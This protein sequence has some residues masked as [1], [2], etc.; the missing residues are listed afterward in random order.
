MNDNYGVHLNSSRGFPSYY[1]NFEL[2]IEKETETED[3][4]SDNVFPVIADKD[5][6]RNQF[7]NRLRLR[8]APDFPSC[9]NNA[10]VIET[11]AY[12]SRDK[13]NEHN[14]RDS[15]SNGSEDENNDGNE[16]LNSDVEGD[17]VA[18]E[19][20]LK[21]DDSL[22]NELQRLEER[23]ELDFKLLQKKEAS[24]KKKLEIKATHLNNQIL[25]WNFF[26]GIRV[27]LDQVLS[28][29]N[30]MPWPLSYSLYFSDCESSESNKKNL[31]KCNK[32]VI[33]FLILLFKLQ[34]CLI[35][36]NNQSLNLVGAEIPL[37][38][39]N[40][41]ETSSSLFQSRKRK[42]AEYESMPHGWIQSEAL[43]WQKLDASLMKI[44]NWSSGVIDE[45]NAKT[46]L[47]VFQK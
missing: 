31:I 28:H 12:F 45:W 38:E 27:H 42:R 2:D 7:N 14:D 21:I 17:G 18:S 34:N 41:T 11:S 39:I 6:K 9:I 24:E 26:I 29:A 4:A 44:I 37:N 19:R 1:E 3:F 15:S 46:C 32:F 25:L 10:N 33:Q 36:N 30:L 35:K 20:K 13:S 8:R 5:V 40:E 43:A 22:L 23:S 16:S 47:K